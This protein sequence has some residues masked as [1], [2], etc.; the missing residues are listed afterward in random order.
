L[1]QVPL[2]RHLE[3]FDAPPLAIIASVVGPIYP[4]TG[5]VKALQSQPA[6]RIPRNRSALD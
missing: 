1:K 2:N 4:T 3:G 6:S 5:S